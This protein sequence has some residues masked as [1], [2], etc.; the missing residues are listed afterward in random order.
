MRREASGCAGCHRLFCYCL[1]TRVCEVF[2]RAKSLDRLYVFH[3]IFGKRR[4][5]GETPQGQMRERERE[6][7][8]NNKQQHHVQLEVDAIKTYMYRFVFH[9]C[10]FF[11]V[12]LF[13]FF[14]FFFIVVINT[15]PSRRWRNVDFF[16]WFSI[17]ISTD[18]RGRKCCVSNM[19]SNKNKTKY[20]RERNYKREK[21]RMMVKSRSTGFPPFFCFPNL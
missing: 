19:H 2:S 5:N 15:T 4:R 20:N 18:R 12:V 8:N 6:E 13:F 10:L 3:S 1:S 14:F 9:F 16:I 7:G 21:E 11:Y 17:F